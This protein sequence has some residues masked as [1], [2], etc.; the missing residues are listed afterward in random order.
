MSDSPRKFRHLKPDE[1]REM[2][3]LHQD[4]VP[5]AEIARQLSVDPKTVHCHVVRF[6]RSF[7]R[8]SVYVVMG[9]PARREC[10]HPSLKCLVCGMAQDHMR[11][12][13]LETIRDLK[14]ELTRVKAILEKHDLLTE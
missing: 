5:K 1:I 6:E 8:S 11:R 2:I 14:T 9:T 7:N 12:R 3:A 13:E 4:G 10:N